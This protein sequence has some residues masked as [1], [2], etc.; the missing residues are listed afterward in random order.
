MIVTLMK[1]E[2]IFSITLPEKING[3]YWISDIDINGKKR[4]IISVEG[5]NGHWILKE[6]KKVKINA[7]SEDVISLSTGKIYTVQ[8]FD[9]EAPA[10]LFAEPVNESRQI[11]K[12]LVV[13]NDVQ[14]RIG[15]DAHN[16]ICVYN[17][18]VSSNHATMVYFNNEWTI[19]D[20]NSTNGTYVNMKKI[21]TAKLEPGDVIFI[22]G[23]KIIVGSNFIAINNPDNTVAYDKRVL[24][25]FENQ[26][27]DTSKE[28]LNEEELENQYFYRSPRFKREISPIEI[29]IDPPPQAEKVDTTPMALVVGPA[30]TMGMASLSTGVFSV[31]NA[32]STGGNMMSVAPTLV[33][34]F[35]MLL[36]MVLWPI[37]TRR[38]EKKLKAKMERYRQ[39][40]YKDYIFSI[41]DVIA[42]EI[43]N[44]SNILNENN[45]DI[46]E[47]IDRIF[48]KKDNLWERV[49][50]QND[51]LKLRVGLG[52]IPL[53]GK[54]QYPEKRFS[55]ENDN[56]QDE[57]VALMSEPKKLNMVPITYSF[58]DSKVCGIIGEKKS[59][60]QDF[61]K[62]M[63]V[64]MT[65][66]HSYDE[67]KIVII[68]S[69]EENEIWS[70][71]K[72]LP[73]IWDDDKNIRFYATNLNEAK[74]L[75]A[76]FEK[77][78]FERKENRRNSKEIVA[79][80]YLIFNT[81]KAVSEKTELINMILKDD[82]HLSFGI[83]NIEESLNALPKECSMVIEIGQKISKIYDRNDITGNRTEF[84]AD[85]GLG[86]DL[87]DVTKAVGNIHLDLSKN[88]YSLPGML[89]FLEMFNQTKIEHLNPLTRWKENNPTVS[90]AAPIG[91][92]TLG[93]LF[94]LDL[95]EKF[96]GP[97]G[98]VA[99]MTGSGKSEFIITYILSMAVNYH[100]DEVAFILIDYK[101]GGLTGAFED[102]EKGIKL[103][104]LAGTITNLDGS[105]VKRSLIS[106]QS[107]LRRR[108]AV[109]N[110]ARK[111]SNE[112]TMDIYKYQKLY[113][114][115]VVSEPIPHLFIISDEFAELKT[116][117][118]EFMVQLISAARIG[119]SLGV[120]L[121]L[122]TQ[123]PS[124]VVDDQ[125][126]SNTRFRVCL[127]VQDKSDS[128]DMIK[129]PE[130][131]ELAN[132]GRFYLQVGFNEFF[133]LGQSAWCG[134]PYN[135]SGI[136]EKN[137]DNSIKVI[138]NI[139]RV[140]KEL[141]PKKVQQNNGESTKQI[142][143]IVKYL[144]DLARE[145]NISVRPLWLDAIPANIYISDIIEKYCIQTETPYILNPVM[146][147]LDDPFNQSQEALR[148]SLTEDGNT[149]IYGVAGSGKLTFITTM[150]Y[151]L[152]KNHSP[153]YLNLY[154]LDFGAETLKMFEKA[155]Q[156]G[157]VVLSSEAER[158]INLMKL[159][160][161]EIIERKK[162]F[163]DYG[164]DYVS[165]VKNSGNPYP[166]IVVVINN[167]S[168]FA[169]M[170]E[171]CEEIISFVS[172]EGIKY[173][174]YFVVTATNTGSVRFRLVQNFKRT[175]VMQMNDKNDYS[176]LLGT[177]D[178]TYPAEI[179]G[180]GILKTD[181][182]YE[183][184][185]A[186]VADDDDVADVVKVLVDE[187][188]EKYSG[189]KAKRIPVL[190][191]RVDAEYFANDDITLDKLPIGVNKKKLSVINHNL[192]E[193]YLSFILAQDTDSVAP[194]LQGIA[195]LLA[196]K[197]DANIVVVDAVNKFVEDN[198][199]KYTYHNNSFNDVVVDI[200]NEL[201]S[202]HKYCKEHGEVNSPKIIYI[203]N[204]LEKLK[205]SLSE[206]GKDKLNVL[207][208]NGRLQLNVHF[209]IGD[210]GSAISKVTFDA[211]YKKHCVNVSGIW[212][213]DG[214]TDQYVLKITKPTSELYQEMEKGFGLYI[215]KGRYTII[216]LL[217]SKFTEIEDES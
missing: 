208:E 85:I 202:R 3:R 213:G 158:V 142:V 9:E 117:Q 100:P 182:T 77:I 70:S 116:Q 104:H 65:S 148:L 17:N 80:Y 10:Y 89:T 103:P 119:R 143:A 137:V 45:V 12:K 92:D 13:A 188:R 11:Y 87:G 211:W 62:N 159:L 107:E 101:G 125:I 63:I 88:A 138:D 172:R 67:L 154:I 35:S 157:G 153:E 183:F 49:I 187:L 71:L 180:R 18:F 69:E 129:R 41:K 48:S 216:K 82:E 81:N 30:I 123:K 171:E 112:G 199:R 52:N 28:K 131:A 78:Y 60:A 149:L 61:V 58:A 120:H 115:G 190:P 193:N 1:S 97:H 40:K 161:N 68:T 212:V 118:P 155:P 27:T 176:A 94:T 34:S 152:I 204:S 79:P 140:V 164:G 175:F 72:W 53:Q 169:E 99:G 165:Y 127:K 14:L 75:S 141:K 146:G 178:G 163:V 43:Q 184:Q 66:L 189:I 7:Q 198:D 57:L 167:Y 51:F 113:R 91:V 192:R 6:T 111:V 132:T 102:A 121:I 46:D 201:V 108:Q 84:L 29:K 162:L 124:G 47:C 122:A 21:T 173:G 23:F 8:I 144:S 200:F 217:T 37:L 126:W 196:D 205:E 207:L 195:E 156:V 98:L 145:E 136:V 26:K 191:K 2:R 59:L 39:A 83:I 114:N 24:Y 20:N 170:Y 185:T 139:G 209:I 214:S 133:A 42:K 130:A 73:H 74:D 44:Q 109:F 15:R 134:A 64:R 110:E 174:V 19:S 181:R 177:V 36:G 5:V 168:A 166:N 203:I 93:Q 147:E 160:K 38:H 135:E 206:D 50:G 90:L 106:I 55:L 54:I 33:M 151:E 150:I 105:A 96:Q 76:Y 22:M 56:L 4:D 25:D 16:N 179:K 186:K 95:H 32:M 31:V 210:M 197:I 215:S 194:V 86:C 128:M